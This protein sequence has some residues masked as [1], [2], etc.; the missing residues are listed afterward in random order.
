MVRD[1]ATFRLHPPASV[2]DAVDLFGEA[3][4]VAFQRFQPVEHVPSELHVSGSA[5]CGSP[6]INVEAMLEL[7][8]LFK[9]N[10]AWDLQTR[11]A[12]WGTLT[13][14]G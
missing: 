9:P 2:G 12:Q 8:V 10:R 6:A 4:D 14:T 5:S 7:S 3:P 13:S 1:A 11:A